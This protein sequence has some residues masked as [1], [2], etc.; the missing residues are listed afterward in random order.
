MTPQVKIE[1]TK[2]LLCKNCNNNTFI[3]CFLMR[4]V[5][6]LTIG[7]SKKTLVPIEVMQ[8][9]KCLTVLEDT[10]PPQLLNNKKPSLIK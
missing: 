10:V 6:P 1:E 7:A 3:G 5:N 4:E 8:C 2:E 9:S